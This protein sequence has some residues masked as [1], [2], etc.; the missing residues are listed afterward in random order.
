MLVEVLKVLPSR[1]AAG[2]AIASRSSNPTMCLLSYPSTSIFGTFHPDTLIT[3]VA[4]LR[5]ADL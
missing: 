1:N 4:P 3:G 2:G 5:S